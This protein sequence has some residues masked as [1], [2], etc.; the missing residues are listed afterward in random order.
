MTKLDKILD[1][2]TKSARKDI[3]RA[4]REEAPIPL[5][6]ELTPDRRKE[7]LEMIYRE[8]KKRESK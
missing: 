2:I 1:K 3:K 5:A 6:R 4:D 7:C 8:E